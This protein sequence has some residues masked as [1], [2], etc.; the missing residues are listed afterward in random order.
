MRRTQRA[1]IDAAA[2]AVYV[3]AATS[4]SYLAVQDDGR[5][6]A[7]AGGL[8]VI[9]AVL[10]AT[11]QRRLMYWL[12]FIPWAL[13]TLAVSL[14]GG[15]TAGWNELWFFNLAI[16]GLLGVLMMMLT[17]IVKRRLHRSMK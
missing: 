13:L 2:G 14:S 16:L 6:A 12:A 11:T 7:A 4:L 10:G 8:L 5:S 3:I 1:A 9:A 15:R 17:R